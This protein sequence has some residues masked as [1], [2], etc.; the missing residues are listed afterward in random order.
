MGN[1]E[2]NKVGSERGKGGNFDSRKNPFARERT[3]GFPMPDE[4]KLFAGAVGM[5]LKAGCAVIIGTTRDGGALVIT[6][7]DG[8][9]RHRTYCSN[10]QELAEACEA[11]VQ[12][13]A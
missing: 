9:D 10:V 4:V 11:M 5:V 12:N 3:D 1:K 13:F 2:P 6:I 7:L 8:D